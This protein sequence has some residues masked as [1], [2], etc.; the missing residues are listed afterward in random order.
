LKTI[1][2]IGARGGSKGV[3]GKNI[4]PLDNKPLIA[5]AIQSALKS[6]IFD[7]VV[8]STDDLA[9]SRVAKKYGAEIP[10]IRPKKLATDSAG[11]TEVMLHGI[12]ELRRM[13]Y[14]FDVLVNRDCTVPFMRISDMKNAVKLLGEKKCNA[15]YGVYRQ[16]FNPYFN[17]M[18]KNSDGFLKLCKKLKERPQ[19]R[20]SA[21]VVYQ[22]NGLFV[23][24]VEKFLK[25]KT[26]LLPMSLPYEIPPECGIMID[27]ELE[28]QL[29]EMMIK[30][31][32]VLS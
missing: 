24:D 14:E 27:T 20:Q 5:Y 25:Y 7:H 11:F 19:S 13:G 30:K 8:V 29:A 17:M 18:E 2:F 1:C 32:L 23:Y 9:I 15:V 10:F 4:R 6:G 26:P 31:R 16:H 28:F 22:L 3:P 12:V 21:P